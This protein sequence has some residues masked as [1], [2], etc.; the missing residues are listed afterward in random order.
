MSHF[1]QIEDGI[2]V[3]VIVA[4]QDFIDTLDGTWVQTSYNT[5][6]GVHYSPE[7]G[8]PDGG[9]ALR[10]NYASIG[11]SYDADKDAFIPPQPFP[12]WSLVEE[13]CLWKPPVDVPSDGNAYD[14]DEDA[15]SWVQ[16][17]LDGNPDS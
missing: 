2:V 7:T 10:K 11:Y 4:E 1:A 17:R 16:V 3:N 13:T 6:G 8:E 15:Q 12:S 9:V 5:F 14:W